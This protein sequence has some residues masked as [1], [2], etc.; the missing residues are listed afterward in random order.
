MDPFVGE[1]RLFSGTYIPSGWLACEG[2]QL[3]IQ[4]NQALYS[5]IGVAF[6]GDA[7]TYFNLPNL[8]G[9][10]ALCLGAGPGLTPRTQL[11]QSLGAA[12][13]S[14][15]QTQVPAHQ[16]ALMCSTAP[17]DSGTPESAFFC[18]SPGGE[19]LYAPAPDG[20]TVMAAGMLAGAGGG[21]GHNNMQPALALR[22][23]I[24]VN[25]IYPSR[26]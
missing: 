13:V 23:M 2:Q 22:Y 4:Q 1:I 8:T 25:G 18:E 24:A 26:G 9:S 12:T 5:I 16:H 14:L 20:K 3:T 11:G 7:K 6:G 19:L 10:V 17:Y 15:D 21:G